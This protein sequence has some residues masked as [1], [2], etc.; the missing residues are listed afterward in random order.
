MTTLDADAGTVNRRRVAHTPLPCRAFGGK[1]NLRERELTELPLANSSTYY[2]MRAP[3]MPAR[4]C[5]GYAILLIFSAVE[6]AFLPI[7]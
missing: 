7:K 5:P 4:L 6:R 1:R 2:A 3:T